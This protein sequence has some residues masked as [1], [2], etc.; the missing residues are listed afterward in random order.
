[1]TR[2]SELLIAALGWAVTNKNKELSL[3]VDWEKLLRLTKR[4][5]L[6]PL[7]GD[8]LQKAG[9]WESVPQEVAKTL[10]KAAMH[11]VYHDAQ[12]EHIRAKLEKGLKEE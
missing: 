8:G 12:T 11:A 1:M 4:H 9:C 3:S 10:E 7:L 2:E 5:M 6:L